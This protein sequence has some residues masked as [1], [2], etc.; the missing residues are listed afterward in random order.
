MKESEILEILM[1]W[2]YWG[3]FKRE[4]IKRESYFEK[5]EKLSK[6]NEIVVIKGVRRSGKSSIAYQFSKEKSK[7][8]DILIINLEDPRFPTKMEAKDLQKIFET[9]L[10]HVNPKGPKYVIIDEVQYV[11]KWERFARYLSESKG[12]KV[13]V[14]G[15]S[16]KLLSEEYASILTGRHLDVEVFP[17]SFKE[18]LR[19][20]GYIYKNKLEILKNKF[21]IINLLKEYIEF[22]GFPE[23]V[24]SENRERK[25]ELLRTYFFDILIK[26]I[27][28]RFK[29]R[30]INVIEELAKIYVSNIST[31]QSF[32]SLKN[33]LK[34]SLDSVERFSK[35]FEI[36]R[37]FLFLNNFKYSVKEQIRSKKK[38][39]SIDTGFFNFL[40][41]KISENFGRLMENA[42]AIE[43]VRRR[44][45]YPNLEIFYLKINDK[46]VDFLIKENLKIKQ[47]IQVTYASSKDEIERREIK[48]LIKASE[49]LK[50]KDLLIITWD[51]EDEIKENN[52]VIKC[53]P[54]WKWLL[55]V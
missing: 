39:Y 52:K 4:F 27:S 6:G 9:F 36:A 13:F 35:Y 44:E 55:E 2:N 25:I 10:K 7:E 53:I 34:I 45:F 28:K 42:V 30:K 46:E 17:L 37:L 29:V 11:E 54:L 41:F 48:S 40:G 26:D 21:E 38:V 3:N 5:L 18:F 8:K 12:I 14:T 47:L 16:S 43:L 23:V 32:N 31:I 49:L 51:Y 1:D 22:G 50:C 33:L 15:S 20:K 24:L 19:F